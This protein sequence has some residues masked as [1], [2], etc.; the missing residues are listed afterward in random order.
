MK[1]TARNILIML[2][3]LVV[4]GG[5]SA[6]LFLVPSQEEEESSS[7]PS[8]QAV[9]SAAGEVLTDLEAEDVTSISVK[10]Q[11]DSFQFV[12][13][14]EEFGLQG[15]EDCDLNTTMISSS[16]QTLLSMT[17]SKNLGSRE[18]LKEF[19]LSGESSVE[20]EI[21]CKDGT[22]QKLTLGG[23]AGESAGRYV[24]KDGTVY[25]VANVS[26]QLYG[27]K[28]EYF[29]SYLYSIAERT[30]VTTDEE[31]NES[32]ETLPDILYSLKL[33]GKNYP[34]AVEIKYDESVT[35]G[36]LMT[37][38]IKAESGSTGL[39]TLVEGVKAPTALGVAAVHLT[40]ELLEEY[41]LLEPDATLEFT[42]N[43]DTH[44][45]SVSKADPDGNRYLL[46]DD[47]DVVYKVAGSVAESWAKVPLLKLRMSYI[48]LSNIK[49]VKQLS[50]TAGG[51]DYRFDMTRTLDEE[52]S[53]EDS[54]QY[55]LAVKNAAG[56]DITY[57]DYRGFYQ[58]LISVAVLSTDRVEFSGEP[59]FRVEYG[60][61]DNSEE[62]VIEFYPAENDRCVAVLNGEF[63]GVV[64]KAEIDKLI[65]RLAEV[66]G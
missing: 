29:S 10:N 2:M 12:S 33:S 48:W 64:R 40:E 54:P 53:T 55:D 45:M 14:E 21:N 49:D 15:Y 32:T 8:S 44:T 19:G 57:D 46:L 31:G 36:Y 1:K 30:S 56:K 20:V 52:K 60:Y 26:S 13:M 27:S 43:A 66:H 9:S 51:K 18:D 25:I 65:S 16:V 28:Y 6:W 7:A 41:G 3:V 23:K 11:E 63:N 58:E 62:N 42:L 47:R 34:E 24:L 22:E 50:F 35:S 38:P 5:I 61:F 17:A 59:V 39:T 4:L 37:A